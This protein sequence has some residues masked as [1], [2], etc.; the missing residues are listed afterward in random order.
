MDNSLIF[1]K[2]QKRAEELD[3]IENLYEDNI[4]ANY[5]QSIINQDELLEDDIDTYKQFFNKSTPVLEIGSG[6]G[7]I[8]NP[9]FEEGYNIF[10][11][12]PAK[13]MSEYITPKGR[14]RIYSL[15]L[16]EI[17]TLPQKNI[18]VIIIPATTVSLFSHRDFYDFL[19][20]IKETQPHIK[21]IVFDFLK[22]SFFES[23]AGLIQSSQVNGEKFYNVNFFDSAKERI[24]Y[25]LVSP[26][27]L[28]VSVKYS[29][30]YEVLEK[31]FRELGLSMKLIKDL[32]GY[33]MIEGVFHEE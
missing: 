7:R 12:E 19:K 11:L 23:T 22:E 8:F 31:M 5:Y 30:S 29:Y 27:K 28:G 21:R 3:I 20:K 4:F 33:A 26:K 25:N 16:Q 32:D 13:E 18:E 14:G 17:E 9:L 2:L 15:T 1:N 24:I 6:T 10:G